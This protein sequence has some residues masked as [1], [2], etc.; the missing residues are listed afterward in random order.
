MTNIRVL[1][2]FTVFLVCLLSIASNAHAMSE[3][4]QLV[5][6]RYE[7]E[8]QLIIARYEQEKIESEID[9]WGGPLAGSVVSDLNKKR[10]ACQDQIEALEKDDAQQNKRKKMYDP[11]FDDELSL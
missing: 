1:N 7:E 5:I 6:A 10:W 11:R 4:E 3:E 9:K 8:E 2:K